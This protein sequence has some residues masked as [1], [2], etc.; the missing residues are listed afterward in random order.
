MRLVLPR[1]S[2]DNK[3]NPDYL[4]DLGRHHDFGYVLCNQSDLTHQFR[5]ANGGDRP[6]RIVKLSSS[7]PCC[8]KIGPVPQ[9]IPAMGE[10]I[11]QLSL[12]TANQ[13]G[14]RSASFTLTTDDPERPLQHFSLVATLLPEV[15]VRE[16]A[17]SPNRIAIGSYERVRNT[18]VCRRQGAFGKIA[19]S[20]IDGFDSISARFLSEPIESKVGNGLIETI[21]PVEI[22]IPR[23]TDLGFHRGIYRL[24]WADHHKVTQVITWEVQSVISV[25]PTCLL[26]A[27][28]QNVQ[29]KTII[30]RSTTRPFSVTEVTGARLTESTNRTRNEARLTHRLD[31]TIDP[32][33][34]RS[35]EILDVRITTD[36]PEQPQVIVSILPL[37]AQEGL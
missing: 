25:T 11:L 20:F 7:K 6:I 14:Q 3:Q 32:T 35:S 19:P 5:L 21:L 15:E 27:Q 1:K 23:Q 2:I 12:R 34:V 24:N 29:Y 4:P 37:H 10:A 16:D 30:L 18:V 9:F 31:L 33:D 13:S 8:T 36:H 26:I 17:R 22:T 28:D